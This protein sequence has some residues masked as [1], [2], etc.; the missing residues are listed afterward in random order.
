[1]KHTIERIT[2]MEILDSRGDPTVEVTVRLSDGTTATAGV[3]SGASTGKYE[4]F[5]LRDGD[6]ARY[7]GKGVLKAVRNVEDV[8]HPL[9]Q[10]YEVVRQR[11]IDVAMLE[12]D[13][14]EAKHKLGANAILG[15]SLAVARAASMAAGTPLY[16]YIRSLTDF[17]DR[18]FVLPVPLINVVNGNK[19]ASNNLDIQEFWIIPH[20]AATFA[21]RLRQGSEIFHALGGLMKSR[22]MDTDLGNEGGY[23]PNFP[24]HAEVFRMLVSAIKEA[25]YE[26]GEDIS[27]GID[28]GASEFF[29]TETSKYALALEHEHFTSEEFMEYL[30]KFMREYPIRALEDPLA[31]D[32][33]GAWQTL[34]GRLKAMSPSIRL[35]GDDLFVTNIS[36]LQ[37]GIDQ[38]VAN[39]ILIKPNQ[40]G[41]LS[42]TLDAIMLAKKNGY[43]T[44]ISHRSGETTDSFI[45]NLSV[46]V[47][48]EYIKTG[49]T[50]RGERMAKYN[51][52]LEIE[53]ELYGETS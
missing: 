13:G 24:N 41:T 2:A 7:A 23:A 9:L 21:E 50:A 16:A 22:D 1:M 48:S 12:A 34:T 8:L 47:N 45:A 52:L 33:W 10:G 19:H 49:S 40:I 44:A 26:P 6:A 15:V 4:A 42:E 14:T 29:D 25:R 17:S 30:T 38:G 36:R 31:E 27:L 53:H 51:R 11:E 39:S 32:E 3:P 20:R 37:K 35:I 28:A 5:E 18:D 43:A 46:A